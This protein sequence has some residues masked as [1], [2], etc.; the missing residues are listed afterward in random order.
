MRFCCVLRGCDNPLVIDTGLASNW[1]HTVDR[2]CPFCDVPRRGPDQGWDKFSLLRILE[3]IFWLHRLNLHAYQHET[4]PSKNCFSLGYMK[5]MQV[6][7]FPGKILTEMSTCPA[8]FLGKKC[9]RMSYQ[10]CPSYLH[11]PTVRGFNMRRGLP[12]SHMNLAPQRLSVDV[13][14]HASGIAGIPSP[15]RDCQWLA[16]RSILILINC[17]FSTR[18]KGNFF[19]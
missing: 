14:L 2:C 7:R 8:M 11:A 18:N 6:V 13:K 15:C 5:E 4:S 19:L 12:K 3:L 17:K 10:K 1:P 16:F 9:Q